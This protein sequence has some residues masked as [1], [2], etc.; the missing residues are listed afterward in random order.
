MDYIVH[1]F[2]APNRPI[3]SGVKHRSIVAAGSKFYRST[4]AASGQK[5][6][7]SSSSRKSAAAMCSCFG[8]DGKQYH[9]GSVSSSRIPCKKGFLSIVV[10][11]LA[12]FKLAWL[13]ISPTNYIS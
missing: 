4:Y 2:T 3:A 13:K 7:T 5:T 12:L 6:V 9:A 8:C 10:F 1:S 11:I